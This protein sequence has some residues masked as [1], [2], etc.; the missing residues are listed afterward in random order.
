MEV[1]QKWNSKKCP[2][3]AAFVLLEK[4]TKKIVSSSQDK[5]LDWSS[6]LKK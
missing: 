1:S 2:K 3:Q 4:E 6:K 5:V